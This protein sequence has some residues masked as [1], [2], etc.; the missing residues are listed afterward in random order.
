MVPR[1]GFGWMNGVSSSI[2]QLLHIPITCLAAYQVGLSY[3][4]TGMRRAVSACTSPEVFFGTSSS[5]QNTQAQAYQASNTDAL[6]LAMDTLYLS[7]PPIHSPIS[8]TY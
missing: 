4:S 1:E 2:V 8:P 7:D 5:L 3:L 6:N